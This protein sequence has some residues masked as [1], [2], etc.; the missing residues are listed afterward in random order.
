MPAWPARATVIP[1]MMKLLMTFAAVA[2]LCA[3]C[4]GPGAHPNQAA[5]NTGYVDFH[6]DSTDE[7]SWEV[8]RFDEQSKGFIRVYSELEPP[9]QGVLRLPFEPG[10]HRLRVS[11]LNRV[12]L[13]PVVV[14]VAVKDGMVT[15]VTIKLTPEGTALVN[16]D[17][18][19]LGSTGK[20]RVGRRTKLTTD[21]SSAYR[22]TSEAQPPVPYQVIER[23]PYAH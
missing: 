12:V 6:T 17:K 2:L 3:G 22:L 11:F 14:E 16:R 9:P 8:A 5:P 21:E 19:E 1:M 4:A 7:L 10:A 13:E 18:V 20:G 15:P 23:M